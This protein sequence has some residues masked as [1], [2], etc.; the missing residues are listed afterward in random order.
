MRRLIFISFFALIVAL[1]AVA[2]KRDASSDSDKQYL[3]VGVAFYNLENLFD[4]I[5][6]NG[7]YD[8]E[9]S[10]Q[11][12][13]KWDSDKYWKKVN[14]LARAISAMATPETPLGPAIIGIS[15]VENRLSLIHI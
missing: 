11:G 2:G 9:F 14:N 1:N 7:K 3:I 12:A 6:A 10:P 13:R 15:E 5:N 4:T 8:L